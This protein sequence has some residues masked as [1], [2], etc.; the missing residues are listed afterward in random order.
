MGD[1]TISAKI[2]VTEIF[3]FTRISNKQ[4]QREYET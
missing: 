2:R 1:Q 3:I 4:K